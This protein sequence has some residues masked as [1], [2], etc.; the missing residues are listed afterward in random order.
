MYE[1]QNRMQ[2]SYASLPKC[3]VYASNSELFQDLSPWHAKKEAKRQSEF[4][5]FRRTCRQGKQRKEILQNPQK[6]SCWYRM[7]Q[8]GTG[9]VGK[10]Q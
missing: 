4:S 1:V 9:Q 3:G 8:D 7:V 10:G 5:A 6:E 2:Q